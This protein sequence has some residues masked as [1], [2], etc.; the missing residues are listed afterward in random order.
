MKTTLVIL[1]IS[2]ISISSNDAEK[3]CQAGYEETP[4]LYFNAQGNAVSTN[5]KLQL[6]NKGEKES[7]LIY[8]F[9]IQ[10]TDDFSI[11]LNSELTPSE[12]DSDIIDGIT[13]NFH[14]DP[15]TK[16]V[17]FGGNN[18]NSE[19][20][21]SL[22]HELDLWRNAEAGD[23]SS[24]TL[25]IKN[26]LASECTIL[27]NANSS[28][29]NIP[30]FIYDKTK[31]QPFYLEAKYFNGL[32]S[33]YFNNFPEFSQRKVDLS[34][35]KDQA[36]VS[37]TTFYRGQNRQLNIKSAYLCKR[38]PIDLEKS[39][40]SPGNYSV[41]FLSSSSKVSVFQCALY[42]INGNRILLEDYGTLIRSGGLNILHEKAGVK[43]SL[44]HEIEL[45]YSGE[46]ETIT[47][48]YDSSTIQT[49]VVRYDQESKSLGLITEVK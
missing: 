34:S 12:T 49:Q 35:L 20:S 45:S 19:L 40:C 27:E 28:Q 48:A 46:Y 10:I 1:L 21:N 33:F 41:T 38:I 4:L 44:T 36:Y 8:K 17:G 6:S 29:V 39:V 7:G 18:G 25:S 47:I 32:S 9:P 37:F 5:D 14:N 26:C 11:I 43:V 16:V 42:D 24:K 30:S 31:L 2:I 13:I 23:L 22:I 15:R 3:R